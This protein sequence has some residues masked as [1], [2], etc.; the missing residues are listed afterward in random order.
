MA[1]ISTYIF[2]ALLIAAILAISLSA[3]NHKLASNFTITQ[4]AGQKNVYVSQIVPMDRTLP[5]AKGP[6]NQL[7]QRIIAQPIY[8]DIQPPR[9]FDTL[10]IKLEY[11][12]V[13]VPVVFFGLQR[14]EEQFDLKLIQNLN[15]DQVLADQSRWSIIQD[16]DIYLLQNFQNKPVRFNTIEDFATSVPKLSSAKI[17]TV[18]YNLTPQF[19]L[20]NY[21]P[22]E[23]TTI[24]NKSLR[25]SHTILTYIKNENL[26]FSF[27]LQDI[28]RKDGPDP[29]SIYLYRDDTLL[30]EYHLDDDSNTE[31]AGQPSSPRTINVFRSGLAEGVYK[32]VLAVNDDIFFRQIKTSQSKFVFQNALYLTDNFE[33]KS[34]FPDISTS[35]SV[36][37]S[38]AVKLS[39]FTSHHSGLQT[40]KVAGQSLSLSDTH[41]QVN[42]NVANELFQPYIQDNY[43]IFSP[44]NDIKLTGKGV[45]AFTVESFFNPMFLP[46]DFSAPKLDRLDY[47]IGRYSPPVVNQNQTV[48]TSFDLHGA[49]QKDGKFR[50]SLSA[51]DVFRQSPID[52]YKITFN[53]SGQPISF[54]EPLSRFFK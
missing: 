9:S 52:I 10:E 26:S 4:I 34:A 46:L 43:T 12:N 53:F 11:K 40:L 31:H 48:Q 37:Y 24:Y 35:S 28:N 23:Q 50:V 1:R 16:G 38:N 5:P 36:I 39:A 22:S 7:Y 20:A 42:L 21:V 25:G 44:L 13:S 45:F 51:P 41:S 15:F 49:Y 19:R 33:Y 27:I 29:V 17:S 32:L 8:W 2:R 54:I 14:G 47:I 6:N 30:R 3:I 18:N